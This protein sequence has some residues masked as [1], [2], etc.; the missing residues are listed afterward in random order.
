MQ[1]WGKLAGIELMLPCYQ[2]LH[3]SCLF[4]KEIVKILSF[5]AKMVSNNFCA[6]VVNF[7]FPNEFYLKNHKD[8]QLV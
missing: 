1:K 4:S 2:S 7:K 6:G 3:L 8:G 5:F